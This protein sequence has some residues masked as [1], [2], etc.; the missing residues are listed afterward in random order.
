MTTTPED[1]KRARTHVWYDTDYPDLFK[2][3]KCTLIEH[4]ERPL[5]NIPE[6]PRVWTP[7]IEL[8]NKRYKK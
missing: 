3:S 6:C 7:E 2:C 4:R 8:M 5:E 1:W